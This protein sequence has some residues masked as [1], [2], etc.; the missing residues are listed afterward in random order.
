MAAPDAP[1]P[2]ADPTAAAPESRGFS[3]VVW[4]LA[5]YGVAYAIYGLKIGRA[6][7]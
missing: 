6:H 1:V 5:L 3:P 2:H 4:V 7:V